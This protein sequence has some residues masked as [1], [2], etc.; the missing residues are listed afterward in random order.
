MGRARKRKRAPGA[1]RPPGE[2]GAK[3]AT[4]SLRLPGYLREKLV[5]AAERENRS[6]SYEIVVRLNSTFEQA[7]PERLPHV[8]ALVEWIAMHVEGIEAATGKEWRRDA[9]TNRAIR[10]AVD[11]L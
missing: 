2:L 9:W 6:L 10:A 11:Y 4:L 7:G 8:R 1:G 5:A 3:R